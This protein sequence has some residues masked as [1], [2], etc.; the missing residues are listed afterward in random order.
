MIKEDVF[1][2]SL[3]LSSII[4]ISFSLLSVSEILPGRIAGTFCS[5]TES[6]KG[7]R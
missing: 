3:L 6:L 4:E 5:S 2:G 7:D 1:S